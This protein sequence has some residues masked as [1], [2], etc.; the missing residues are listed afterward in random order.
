MVKLVSLTEISP[1]LVV[2]SVPLHADEIAE[3]EVRENVELFVAER[4]FLRVNLDA[5]ALVAHVNEH[6][7][8]P[9]RGA[10]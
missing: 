5:P 3:V 6:G 7:F 2:N 9:C 4:I 1:V 10:R 8:C